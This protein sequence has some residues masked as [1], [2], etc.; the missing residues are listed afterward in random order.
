MDSC[1]RT[2]GSDN[3]LRALDASIDVLQLLPL[4]TL[5]DDELLSQV[6]GRERLRRRL[7]AADHALIAELDIRAVASSLGYASTAKLLTAVTRVAPGEAVGRVRAAAVLGQRAALTGELLAPMFPLVAAAQSDGMISDRHAAIITETIR[8]LPLSV[9]EV[10]G[11]EVEV[12][13]TEHAHRLNPAALAQAAQRVTALLD[14]DG[15]LTDEADRE[16]RRGLTLTRHRDGTSTLVGRL[17]P[18]L[19]EKFATATDAAAAPIPAEPGGVRDARSAAQRLHDAVG[20]VVDAA[21]GS[22]HLRPSG[23]RPATVLVSM[24]LTQLE[25]HIHIAQAGAGSG[26]VGGDLVGAGH[27]GLLSV[28]AALRL[29][30][31]A[32][33]ALI[34]TDIEAGGGRVLAVTTQLRAATTTQRLALAARDGGC[35]FPDCTVPPAWT[36]AHHVV[37]WARGGLTSLDNLTLVCGHHHQTF[38]KNGWSC[39]MVDGSPHWI[40]PAFIDPARRPRTNTAHQVDFHQLRVGT[41]RIPLPA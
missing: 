13:L 35:S 36:Q 6:R 10:Q 31:Q 24:T 14:A 1:G 28:D 34:V 37:E 2:D 21:L 3:V 23:G 38:E 26:L 4:A 19:A 29:P 25:R 9:R 20:D 7:A 16:R 33:V 32:R 40:P 30:D 27:G 8:D 5:T 11:G 12:V 39:Q 22:G 18:E 41:A 15:T 17:T